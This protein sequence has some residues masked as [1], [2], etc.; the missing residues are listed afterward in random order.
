MVK[1]EPGVRVA[2]VVSVFYDPPPQSL[3]PSAIDALADYCTG[4]GPTVEC[5]A[6][7]V[8]V[9]PRLEAGNFYTD[10]N[11]NDVVAADWQDSDNAFTFSANVGHLM[12]KPGVYTIVVW[13]DRGDGK[14]EE[15]LVELSIFVE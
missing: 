5:G 12:Q 11:A 9:L 8:R 4:G 2:G 7:V 15:K 1:R 3:S 13:R 10:L 6:P 14:L